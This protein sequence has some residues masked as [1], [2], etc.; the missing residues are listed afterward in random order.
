MFRYV[1]LVAICGKLFQL[2]K[3]LF[4]IMGMFQVFWTKTSIVETV[5][6][7]FRT[8]NQFNHVRNNCW[9]IL[10]NNCY[11]KCGNNSYMFTKWPP[12]ENVQCRY[13]NSK[14]NYI[15]IYILR[16]KYNMNQYDMEPWPAERPRIFWNPSM[17]RGGVVGA[18][19]LNFCPRRW[20]AKGPNWVNIIKYKYQ[21]I[22]LF[23]Y[24]DLEQPCLRWTAWSMYIVRGY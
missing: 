9:L 12:F 11:I 20:D 15:Y 4:E 22:S 18:S 21:A 2:F 1:S 14:C 24:D 19:G 13:A 5:W 8:M 7:I 6:Q 16:T 10:L 3:Q 17:R 23:G